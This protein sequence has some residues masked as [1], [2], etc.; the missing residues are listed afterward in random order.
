MTPAQ[1]PKK[2]ISP[3]VWI[4]VAV[5][6]LFVMIGLAVVA[7]G[8]FI[9]HKVKQAGLDTELMASNP[10]LAITKLIAATNPD[11]DLVSVDERKGVATLREKKTGKI[12]TLNFEDIKNGRMEFT[13]DKNQKVSVNTDTAGAIEVKSAE[14]TARIGA[15]GKVPDWIPAYP[16]A[17]GEASA[18]SATNQDGESGMFTFNTSDAPDK[19]IRTYEDALKKSGFKVNTNV[20]SADGK[21]S[22][23]FV[24]ASN[25]QSK[26]EIMVS[27]GVGES[28]G[29]VVSVTYSVKK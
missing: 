9:V 10:G 11:V 2:K 17:K 28:S 14:G 4:L 16:G 8:F 20:V 6:G 18:F 5:A 7:T 21:A 22:G 19:V 12:V 24:Q 1:P 27:L 26:R 23:G 29:S 25:E 15:G 13:D 3:I